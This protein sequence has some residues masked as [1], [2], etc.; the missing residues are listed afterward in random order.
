MKTF[1]IG[2]THFY[3]SNIIKHCKR[4]FNDEREMN[5][6]LFK[7]WNAVVSEDDVV[8]HLGDLF[9]GIENN[10]NIGHIIKNLNGKKILIR[11]N[12]D[13]GDDEFFKDAGFDHVTNFI[14]HNEFFLN[15]YPCFKNSKYCKAQELENI[16]SFEN[17]KCSKI[18]HGHNHNNYSNIPN[19]DWDDNIKRF[20][21]SVE[22]IKYTPIELAEIINTLK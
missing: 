7:N 16:K 3:H 1:L 11:G 20:N 17:S 21:C 9:N 15:H 14:I 22:V 2:D 5:I 6:A 18:I 10:D 8:I 4:P 12:H 19:P 13:Y